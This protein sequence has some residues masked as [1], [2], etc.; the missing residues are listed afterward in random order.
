MIKLIVDPYCDTCRDFKASV[1]AP[2]KLMSDN[3]DVYQTDTIVQCERR[4]RCK[5]IA[6]YMEKK[7][8]AL[9]KEL[10]FTASVESEQDTSRVI[11]GQVV[12]KDGDDVLVMMSDDSVEILRTFGLIISEE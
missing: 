6:K 1:T 2:T 3:H 9:I 8:E 10:T 11:V 4:N 5:A 12:S 7:N